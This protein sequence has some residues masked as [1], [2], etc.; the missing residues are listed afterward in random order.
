MATLRPIA[1]DPGTAVAYVRQALRMPGL[2]DAEVAPFLVAVE[3]EIAAGT[4]NGALR[5]DTGSTV[6]VAIWD[7][8]SEL[9][10]T[11]QVLYLTPGWQTPRE[12]A[13]FLKE[14]QGRVG[15]LLFAP[16][17][18]AGVSEAEESRAMESVGFARFARSEMRMD[19][20]GR[21]PTSANGPATRTASVE[22]LPALAR[23]HASA[24][25]GQFD[26]YLF[27]VYSDPAKDAELATREILTGR[28]GEFLP[29]ASSVVEEHG[30]IRAAS[31]VVRAPYGPLI[32]D[33]MVDPP[34]WGQGLGRA[35]VEA[36]LDALRAR[37]E[38]VAVLNV[39]EGNERA[40]GLYR[41]LGFVR[42]LGP[43]R[44]WYSRERIPGG[45]R[46]P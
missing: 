13:A 43:S 35:V 4:A 30:E 21:R 12:Y 14:I 41:Q 39:T 22:D 2:A 6:G 33:V 29:W 34:R 1:D 17:F 23:L 15:P 37:G 26:Q 11:V 32:A 40:L 27:L 36:T 38:S 8:S 46:T 3:R 18:L 20:N 9:G 10:T 45:P 16:G 28:W 7:P 44:G 31:L 5:V 19:L 25:R 42:S 24:Y